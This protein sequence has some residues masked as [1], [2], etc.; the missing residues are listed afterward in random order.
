MLSTIA[1]VGIAEVAAYTPLLPLSV[2]LWHARKAHLSRTSWSSQLGFSFL[3]LAHGVVTILS[4]TLGRQ[5]NP[6]L[7]VETILFAVAIV[8]LFMSGVALVYLLFVHA[9]SPPW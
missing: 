7:F 8:P 1:T 5:G 2:Y 3:R 6:A 4:Q 9:P